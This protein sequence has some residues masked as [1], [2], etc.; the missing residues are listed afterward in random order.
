MEFCFKKEYFNLD[1][2]IIEKLKKWF[3]NNYLGIIAVLII[4]CGV[5]GI[6]KS[7]VYGKDSVYG[8]LDGWY[9]GLATAVTVFFMYVQLI[10]S[11]KDE[12]KGKIII[13]TRSTTNVEFVLYNSG[14][15]TGTFQFVGIMNHE[16]FK[17]YL[18]GKIDYNTSGVL[19]DPSFEKIKEQLIVL[20]GQETSA[21]YQFP[22]NWVK[23]IFDGYNASDNQIAYIV[24]EDLAHNK[25]VGKIKING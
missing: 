22:I 1:K 18:N 25:V 12:A 24:F 8:T 21:I 4:S 15:K 13:L 2:W 6:C 11:K 7:F 23:E 20:K 9:S 5:V 10:V 17:K 16:E 3:K 14:Q 19:I